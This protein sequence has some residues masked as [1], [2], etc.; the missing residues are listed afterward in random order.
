[1]LRRCFEHGPVTPGT[2]QPTDMYVLL[3]GI[4][5]DER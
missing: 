2:K 1:M 5:S 4:G 3:G